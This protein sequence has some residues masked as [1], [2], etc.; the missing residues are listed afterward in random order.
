M[1]EEEDMRDGLALARAGGARQEG[2]H[3]LPPRIGALLVPD[4]RGLGLP[5]LLL[6][7]QP[8]SLGSEA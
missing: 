3:G 2:Q 1:D 7:N 8:R 6:P 5:A 4:P